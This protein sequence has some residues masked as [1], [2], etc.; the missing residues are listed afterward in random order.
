MNIL[1]AGGAGYIGSHMCKH[2]LTAGYQPIVLDN[3]TC[4]HRD[5]VKWGPLIEGSLDD[6]ALLEGIFSE[7]AISAVMHFAA[8]IEVGESVINPAKYYQNNVVATLTLLKAMIKANVSHFIFS[9]SAA[10]YGNPV[11]DLINEEHPL[12]PINPY[13]RSKLIVEQILDDFQTAYGL[14]YISLRY[15]NA[16]GADPDGELGE[17]HDPESHLIPLVLKAASGIRKDIKIFGDNYPTRD[18]TCIRD[19]IH[20]SDLAQAHL[21]ALKWLF[22]G[23]A[24]GVYNLG[25]GSGYS[26]HEVLETARKITGKAIPSEIVGR[27]QGDAAVLVSSSEK[28]KYELGW[29][30]QYSE[31]EVIIQ[32]AWNWHQKYPHGYRE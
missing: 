32:H 25:N 19:Y 1:V 9:S 7:Y 29:E 17:D 2:L 3:L 10:V 16:A 21:S 15:F 27:R 5:A 6:Q 14:N 31:L 20:V 8:F 30:P 22:N 23:G 13:G 24:S 4:G 28:A 18:G 26:V 12:H 11:E